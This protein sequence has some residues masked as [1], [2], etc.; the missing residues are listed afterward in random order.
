MLTDSLSL[1]KIKTAQITLTCQG[2]RANSFSN[3]ITLANETDH[4]NHYFNN[5][6]NKQIHEHKT[7]TQKQPW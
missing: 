1:K 7:N 5:H 3:I 2:I 6:I 4:P